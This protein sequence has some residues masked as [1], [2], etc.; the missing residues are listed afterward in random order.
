MNYSVKTSTNIEQE[1]ESREKAAKWNSLWLF[2]SFA[3]S[4][5]SLVLNLD[6]EDALCV[7]VFGAMV[8]VE[9]M[10]VMW[11][12]RC[13]DRRAAMWGYWNQIAFALYF[14]IY[15]LYHMSHPS[16]PEYVT[17]QDQE[18]YIREFVRQ[19]YAAIGI[20]GGVGQYLLALYYKRLLKQI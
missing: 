16:G 14:F 4:L 2:G 11:G 7:V 5:L 20:G 13:K 9:T 17:I 8:Y 19:F 3:V 18:I 12:F 6:L 15:G 10:Y 1:F